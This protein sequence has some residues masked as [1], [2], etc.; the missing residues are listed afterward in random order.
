M[1]TTEK[2]KVSLRPFTIEADHPTSSDLLIQGIPNCRL[3]SKIKPVKEIFDKDRRTHEQVTKSASSNVL[4]GLPS[5]V[6][7]MRISVDPAGCRY[8]VFDPLTDDKESCQ[9][10]AL[11]LKEYTGIESLT[12]VVG[13]KSREGALGEDETKTLVRELFNLVS[14]GEATVIKGILPEKADIDALPGDYLLNTS[15]RARDYSQPRYEKD[16]AAWKQTLNRLGG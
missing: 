1:A 11:A 2:T 6:P 7:G 4:S 5:S 16:L 13:V 9:E 15:D 10:I 3:R 8:K 14:N 12:E